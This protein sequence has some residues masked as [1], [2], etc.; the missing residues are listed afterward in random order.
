MK[1][2]QLA[3][4]AEPEIQ[5][6]LVEN[7][8]EDCVS[9]FDGFAREH[10]LPIHKNLS[11][12]NIAA[13]KDKLYSTHNIDIADGLSETEWK[14]VVEQFQKRHLIA[15]KMGVIDLEFIKKTNRHGGDIGKKVAISESDVTD[16]IGYLGSVAENI[17]KNVLHS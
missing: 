12:Q 3:N 13:A 5:K 14:F 9:V 15:H 16:L 17:T 2:L 8:L 7:A 11:F 10:C 6:K 1:V 4:T